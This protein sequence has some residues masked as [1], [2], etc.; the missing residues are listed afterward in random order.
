M[1]SNNEKS[2]PHFQPI[3]AIRMVLESITPP[4][5]DSKFPDW[6]LES[7]QEEIQYGNAGSVTITRTRDMVA[8]W[9]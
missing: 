4:N 6:A 7:I 2:L 1:V 8:R 9:L 3:L 5:G